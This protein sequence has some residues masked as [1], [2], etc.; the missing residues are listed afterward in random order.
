MICPE[1]L[2]GISGQKGG[3]MD[4]FGVRLGELRKNAGL[5]QEEFAELLD[6]SRQ[7]I[8]KWENDKAYPEMNRLLFMSDYF[9]VSLDYLMR[10]EEQSVPEPESSTAAT[11]DVPATPDTDM[12]E[13]KGKNIF[14]TWNDFHSNLSPKQQTGVIVLYF[15]VIAVLLAAAILLYFELG[16]LLGRV[17]YE[18]LH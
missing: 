5:S 7:S 12:K 9:Q 13:Y 14:R 1:L 18:I 8:S 3:V 16:N 2:L 4:S 6:V 17:F 11:N 15:F 10:G